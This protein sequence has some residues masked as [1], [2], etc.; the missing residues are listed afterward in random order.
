[1][2]ISKF[3]NG[4]LIQ[5]TALRDFRLETIPTAEILPASY[6][7]PFSGK[8]KDQNGSGSCVSQATS[9]Y[10]EVLNAIETK[11]W[12][13]LS[14]KF[15]YSQCFIPPMGSYT[16]DNMSLMCNYGI[17]PETYLPSYPATEADMERK[18]DITEA[19][20]QDALTYTAKSYLTWNNR[21][22]DMFKK[23]I[24]QGNGCVAIAM[25]NNELWKTGDIGLPKSADEFSWSHGIYLVGWSD[26]KKAFHFINSWSES[27]GEN[28]YGWLPYDYITN[29][30][31]YNPMT[32][33]D[34]KNG[35]YTTMQKIIGLLRNLVSLYKELLKRPTVV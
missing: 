12:V 27:W 3:K 8:I 9:Y 24:Y 13:E 28:G 21:S 32:L 4:G 22:I 31:C 19:A 16:K 26:E 34:L 14:P 7:V 17:C 18:S 10:A 33:I 2:D 20:L 30:Y 11:S 15:L 29:G 23:A 35:E 6:E 5:R 1:M 25:G